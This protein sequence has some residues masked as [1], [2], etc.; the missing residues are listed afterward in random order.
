MMKYLKITKRKLKCFHTPT[1]KASLQ[2]ELTL[3]R[4]PISLDAFFEEIQC[5]RTNYRCFDLIEIK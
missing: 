3:D 1:I 5:E 2:L 4:K